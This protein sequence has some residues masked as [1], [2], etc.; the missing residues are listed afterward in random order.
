ME[1][2]PTLVT[3][4]FSIVPI[5]VCDAKYCF[6][7]LDVEG[8][9]RDSDT[10]ILSESSFG[11]AFEYRPE[12][13]NLAQPNLFKNYMSLYVLVGDDIFSLQSYLMKPPTGKYHDEESW[14]YNYRLSRA[15]RTIE[16]GVLTAKW[17]DGKC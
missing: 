2:Q 16:N 7:L 8:F 1:A 6:N 5:A 14:V 15:R 17:S 3:K 13:L 4:I 10:G 12:G 11:Q 9:G